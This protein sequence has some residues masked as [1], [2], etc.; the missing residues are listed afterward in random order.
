IPGAF[1]TAW[2]PGFSL[3]NRY[4]RTSARPQSRLKIIIP[5]RM[6]PT[7]DFAN[8]RRPTAIFHLVTAKVIYHVVMQSLAVC[9]QPSHLPSEKP[10][11]AQTELRN[12]SELQQLKTTS[13]KYGCKQ[14][15]RWPCRSLSLGQQNYV[16]QFGHAR[17]RPLRLSKRKGDP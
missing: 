7:E 9:R 2:E 10:S 12:I 8:V 3:F 5:T 1:P 14:L 17:T 13:S 11:A 16:T 6:E 15:G 4:A